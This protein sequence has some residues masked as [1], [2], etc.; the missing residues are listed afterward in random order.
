MP[1]NL[2]SPK[3]INAQVD[4]VEIVA[5]SVDLERSS[6][7]ITYIESYTDAAGQAVP[8]AEKTLTISGA[9]MAAAIA[10]ADAYAAGMNPVSVYGAIK[11]A[12]Y[13]EIESRTGAT[14]TVE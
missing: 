8:V 2:D 5:F 3:T 9:D 14:G 4:R 12:L 6:M 11:L 7:H 13:D 10:R 1:L